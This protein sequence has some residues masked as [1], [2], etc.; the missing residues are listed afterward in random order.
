LADEKGMAHWHS[1][2]KVANGPDD[3]VFAMLADHHRVL[4]DRH[5]A[6]AAAHV[7]AAMV[8]LKAEDTDAGARE[9]RAAARACGPNARAEADALSAIAGRLPEQEGQPDRPG[10]RRDEDTGM[11]DAL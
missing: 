2:A 3:N 4:T 8:A 1:Q 10:R 5:Q 6:D 9:L 11:L 7:H